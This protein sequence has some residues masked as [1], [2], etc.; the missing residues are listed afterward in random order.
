MC[1]VHHLHSL[2]WT[3]TNREYTGADLER[4]EHKDGRSRE[5][6][7]FDLNKWREKERKRE[8]ES[9]SNLCESEPVGEK[10]C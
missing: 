1:Q 9:E 6:V 3:T 4:E 8:S 10:G 5:N 2:P 7:R